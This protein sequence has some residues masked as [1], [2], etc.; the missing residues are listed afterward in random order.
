[1]QLQDHCKNAA[2]NFAFLALSKIENMQK[3]TA[4]VQNIKIAKGSITRLEC[5]VLNT[6]HPTVLKHSFQS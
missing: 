6:T 1:M 4:K 2:K 5:P 3:K